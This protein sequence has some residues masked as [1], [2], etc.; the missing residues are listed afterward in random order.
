MIISVWSA[1]LNEHKRANW[2]RNRWEK[3]AGWNIIRHV[4][5]GC[6]SQYHVG[7][8]TG[9]AAQSL[10]LLP[11]YFD[12]REKLDHQRY[13]RAGWGCSRNSYID[14]NNAQATLESKA[15]GWKY[16]GN[17]SV[18]KNFDDNPD[19]QEECRV[20]QTQ[21][22]REWP[23]LWLRIRTLVGP[24]KHWSDPWFIC[25]QLR[26]SEFWKLFFSHWDG[27]KCPST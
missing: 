10:G 7:Q 27:E 9:S 12:L 3:F 15:R 18:T 24:W 19:S 22:F 5:A 14:I 13:H 26:D 25:T 6:F 17:L 16:R 1:L 20:W 2:P 8:E 21:S 23:C 4:Y 11:I